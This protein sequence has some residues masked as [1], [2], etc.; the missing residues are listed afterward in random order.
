MPGCALVGAS[1]LKT[2]TPHLRDVDDS[3]QLWVATAVGWGA[4]KDIHGKSF[5]S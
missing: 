1:F 2:T 5:C 4:N 3:A